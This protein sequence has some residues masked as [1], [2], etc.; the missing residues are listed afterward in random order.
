MRTPIELDLEFSSPPDFA[1]AASFLLV[2]IAGAGMSGIARMLRNR[3]AFVRGTDLGGSEEFDHLIAEGF[4]VREG[5]HADAVRSGDILVLTDAIDLATSPEV[6]AARALGCPLA[7][8]SQVLAWLL[9]GKRLVAVTG[10][11]GKTTT[12]SMIGVALRA[13]GLDP[14]I[15]VGAQ[16]PDLGGCMVT[17]AGEVA[18]IEACEAYDS[19][20]DFNPEWVVLTNLEPDHLD[21]HGD[22]AGVKRTVKRF[23]DRIPADGALFYCETDAGACEL[24]SE[25]SARAIPYSDGWTGG[26]LALPGMH[27]RQNAAAAL[28]VVRALGASEDTAIRAVSEFRGAERRFQ[29]QSQGDVTLIDDY[30]H[31]P[32]EIDATLQAVRERFPGRRCVVVFQPHLYSRTADFLPEFGRSLSAADLLVLTDIYPA[33][34]APMPGMS[35]LR[36]GEL[37]SCPVRYIP[38]RHL[39]PRAVAQMILPGDVVIGMGAGTISEFIPGLAEELN[40]PSRKRIVV[41]LGGDSGEREVSLHSGRAVAAALRRNGHEVRE[42]DVSEV[43]LSGKGLGQMHGADRPDAVFLAVHGNRAEDGAIQGLFELLHTPYT[44]SDIQTSAVAMDKQLT[45]V[46]LQSAGLPVPQGLLVKQGEAFDPALAPGTSWVVKPNAQGSTVGLSFVTDRKELCAAIEKARAYGDQVLIEEWLRGTEISVPVLRDRALPVVEIVPAS[47]VYDFASKYEPGATEEIVPARLS[48]EVTHRVQEIA[49]KA[50]QL[51]GCR[52][53]SRTDMIVVGEAPFVLEVN[54]LPG[55]TATSLLPNSAAAAGI[56][57]DQLC[58]E[59]IR[60]AL[61]KKVP[62]S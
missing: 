45:K 21:F 6:K 10:T 4:D 49:L 19:L 57:Y 5:H 18:V 51:L 46:L 28:A 7:R 15:V 41:A 60:D 9:E 39:L 8:R 25:V 62:N 56:G 24:A 11:H 40:R 54:T 34:E 48:A 38:S 31:H 33:R 43:L 50:H 13:C 55:M 17:G 26:E 35:S 29:V 14:T 36:I 27:N 1:A 2:G 52:G 44:G 22:W 58:E 42:L 30:A 3:G 20:R 37:A 59:I 12:T 47:G 16:V 61:E 23:V 53:A 32:K